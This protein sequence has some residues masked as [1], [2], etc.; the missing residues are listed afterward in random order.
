MG[1]YEDLGQMDN[2]I[3]VALRCCEEKVLRPYNR[4]LRLVSTHDICDYTNVT[5]IFAESTC[6]PLILC[7][8]YIDFLFCTSYTL[9]GMAAI[10]RD[11]NKSLP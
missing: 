5:L 4:L 11:P 10:D 6:I 7:F 1:D 9:G 8:T 3:A 2:P